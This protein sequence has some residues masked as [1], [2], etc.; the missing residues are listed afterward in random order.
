MRLRVYVAGPLTNGN[1]RENIKQATDAAKS[2]M[3]HDYAPLCPHLTVYMDG[4][5]PSVACGFTHEEWMRVCLPWVAVADAVLRLPGKSVGADMETDLANELGIPVFNSIEEVVEMMTA[6]GN[7]D[8]HYSSVKDSGVREKFSTGSRRDTR[9]GKGRFDLISPIALHRLARHYEHG[10]KK[11]GDRNWEK[12]QP[13]SRFIDS[14]MRHLNN[15]L[16]G[17]RSEDHLAACAWNCFSAIHIGEMAKS[18][19]LPAELN[20]LDALILSQTPH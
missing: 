2:L 6:N 17:D 11:Y 8:G 10:A 15:F 4:D 3:W 14:A 18:G 7:G 19:S 12:G 5:T 9:E 16:A 13:V 1:L 20:D